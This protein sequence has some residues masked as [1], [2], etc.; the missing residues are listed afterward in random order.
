MRRKERPRRGGVASRGH[1]RA[2]FVTM[3]FAASCVALAA[4]GAGSG[5]MRSGRLVERW[6]PLVGRLA[7]RIAGAQPS[8]GTY[9]FDR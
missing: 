1:A 4:A 2:A 5:S 6:Q 8:A 3:P 9:A 7:R